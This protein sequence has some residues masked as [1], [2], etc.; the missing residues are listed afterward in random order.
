MTL[1]DVTD[2]LCD[3]DTC[4]SVVGGLPA[5]SDR[6]HLSRLFLLTLSATVEQPIAQLLADTD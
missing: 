5:Y 3:A 2:A 4:H 1:F 6:H